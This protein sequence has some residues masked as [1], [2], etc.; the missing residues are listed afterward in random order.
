M[1]LGSRVIREFSEL[2]PS[3]SCAYWTPSSNSGRQSRVWV[4]A[5]CDAPV[6]VHRPS[7]GAYLAALTAFGAHAGQNGALRRPLSPSAQP[8]FKGTGLLSNLT[9]RISRLRL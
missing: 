3:T 4:L 1:K 8:P 7:G 9:L 5:G 2:L 6:F